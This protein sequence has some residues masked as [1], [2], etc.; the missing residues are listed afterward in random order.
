MFDHTLL[1][2][3]QVLIS[4]FAGVLFLQSGFDKV[5][6]FK[7]NKGYIQ[8]VFAKTFFNSFSGILFVIITSFGRIG[9]FFRRNFLFHRRTERFC[10]LGLRAIASFYSVFIYRPTHRQRLR[11]SSFVGRL[12]STN[13][14]RI[15][16]VCFGGIK[17][18][19]RWLRLR[20]ATENYATQPL[21]TT[22]LNHRIK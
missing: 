5:F 2:V 19:F 6:D 14:L 1:K 4:L 11:W 9:F 22:S 8:G 13:G 20:S 3:I 15:V 16:Y 18:F 17:T 12:F 10:H 7:G 21:K